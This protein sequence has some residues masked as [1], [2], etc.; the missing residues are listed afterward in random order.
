[1]ESSIHLAHL[2][3]MRFGIVKIEETAKAMVP[4]YLTM[5]VVLLLL[6]FVPAF[7]MTIPNLMFGK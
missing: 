4:F 5:V 6:T 2:P 1:M 7:S 3:N